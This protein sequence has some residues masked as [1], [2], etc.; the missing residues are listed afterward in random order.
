METPPPHVQLIQM[1]TAHWVARVIYAAAKLGIADLL[2][3]GPRAAADLAAATGTH[4]PSLYRVLR[5]LAGLGVVSEAEGQRFAL[6]PL[7]EALETGASGAARSTI[8][9]LGGDWTWRGW[10]RFLYSV[11]TGRSGLAEAS[12]M[13]VFEYLGKHPDEAALFAETMI[14][15]H[16]AEAPAVAAAYDFS[17]FG[18]IV[19]VGGST[20]N[21]LATILERH[22]RPR[23][24][25]FDL[26]HVIRDASQ[27]LAAR[28]VSGRV[29]LEAGDFFQAV[30]AGGDAY[31]LSHIIHDWDEG[32][33]VTL[34]DNCRRAMGPRG[35]LLIVEMVL[36]SGD[37]PHP[38]KLLDMLM[39][40][41]PG[42]QERT[43]MEYRVLLGKAGF[44]LNRVVPTQS[45]VSVVEASP[46]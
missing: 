41:G 6:T 15:F 44:S 29:T 38:G 46:A 26:P 43:E 8:L 27:T 39:L 19:D 20:G 14:G 34:L 22:P 7:G 36:P 5:T 21:L 24:V 1:G 32:R 12:G 37:V 25:L 35:R 18:T 40:V 28:P 10:E 11:E 3:A 2:A 9:T 23:G 13:S 42:G 33:C 16:G 30:P 4:A 17:E 45:P 31:L